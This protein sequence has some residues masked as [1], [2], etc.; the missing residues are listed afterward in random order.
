MERL[1]HRTRYEF[2]H[3]NGKFVKP[4]PARE[5]AAYLSSYF[6]AG[7]GDKAAITQAVLNP[8]LPRLPLYVSRRLTKATRTTMRNRRR[9][10]HLWVCNARG[11]RKPSWWQNADER[12]DVLALQWPVSDR[13]AIR[14]RLRRVAFSP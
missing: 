12:L 13:L 4:K 2:G 3:V 5:V 7:R 8:E 6:V 10:R 11:L 9:Q 1:S 14:S